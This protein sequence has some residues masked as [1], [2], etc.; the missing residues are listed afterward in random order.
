MNSKIAMES[1]RFNND[2]QWFEMMVKASEFIS[3]NSM[4]GINKTGQVVFASEGLTKLQNELKDQ[5][6]LV[7]P[8]SKCPW[9]VSTQVYYI[10]FNYILSH[11]FWKRDLDNMLKAVQ[12]II[13][14]SLGVNDSHVIEHHNFKNYHKGDNE[15]LIFRIGISSHKYNQFNK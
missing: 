3:V 10:R 12:D 11:G 6:A 5:I 13:F 2:E 9:I 15:Y 4:Y 8:K 7:D 14:T 1:F